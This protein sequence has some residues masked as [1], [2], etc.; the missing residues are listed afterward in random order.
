L[1]AFKRRQEHTSEHREEFWS[2]LLSNPSANALPFPRGAMDAKPISSPAD[3]IIRNAVR[4]GRHSHCPW[5]A[6]KSAV[7]SISQQFSSILGD[8]SPLSPNRTIFTV[9]STRN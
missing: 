5:W 1:T 8:Q 6:V 7:A 3:L 4:G 9:G 2:D